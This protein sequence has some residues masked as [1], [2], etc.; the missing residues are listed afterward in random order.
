MPYTSSSITRDQWWFR[1]VITLCMIAW[2]VYPLL[3]TEGGSVCLIFFREWGR[4]GWSSGFCRRATDCFMRRL[5]LERTESSWFMTWQEL[6]KCDKVLL[7]IGVIMTV[8]RTQRWFV[9]GRFWLA[10]AVESY[11][12]GDTSYCDQIF[13]MRR[14]LLQVNLNFCL[15]HVCQSHCSISSVFWMSVPPL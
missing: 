14:G 11:L 15:S 13:L 8:K 9:C 2:S 6:R 3:I 1:E 10:R 5:F 7:G 4:V 12:R